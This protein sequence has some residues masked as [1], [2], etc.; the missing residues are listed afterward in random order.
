MEAGE[1]QKK[2]KGAGMESINSRLA[3]V[4]KSGKANLGYKATIKSLRQ[5]KCVPSPANS[6]MQ[7]HPSR[8]EGHHRPMRC[9]LPGTYPAL[10]S[11]SLRSQA[12]AHLQ[13]LP[14]APQVGD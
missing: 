3:L 10:L 9:R 5:G 1:I 8:A 13:Q 2:K 14:A 6:H 11:L 4:M 7:S 12:G